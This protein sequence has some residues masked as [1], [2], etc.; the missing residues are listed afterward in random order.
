M[1]LQNGVIA[2]E[3]QDILSPICFGRHYKSI[4]PSEE[5]VTYGVSCN[6]NVIFAAK[7]LLFI[8]MDGR[9][10]HHRTKLNT[11]ADPYQEACAWN[12]G[13]G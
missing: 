5:L 1:P 3:G 8:I 9:I 10:T 6:R 4:R 13:R 12:P 11:P 7:F 2:A